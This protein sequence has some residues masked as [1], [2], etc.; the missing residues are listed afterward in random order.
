M[1]LSVDLLN[2]FERKRTAYDLSLRTAIICFCSLYK[3]DLSGSFTY[4]NLHIAYDYG[5][6]YCVGNFSTGCRLNRAQLVS[7]FACLFG[8]HSCHGKARS[9]ANN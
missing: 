3:L 4:T 9:F 1:L 2:K 8:C 5:V 6:W 7:H